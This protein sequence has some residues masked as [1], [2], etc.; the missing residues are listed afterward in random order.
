[1]WVL[2][3]TAAAQGD[4]D[5][6]RDPHGNVDPDV[7]PVEPGTYEGAIRYTSGSGGIGASDDPC[8]YRVLDYYEFQLWWGAFPGNP[9]GPPPQTPEDPDPD[10]NYE[11]LWVVVWCTAADGF[12]TWLDGFQ[13]GEPPPPDAL[14]ENARRRLVIPL[15]AAQFSPDPTTGASQVVGLETWLWVDPLDTVDQ[16]ITACVPA[17][18]PYA[19]VAITAEFR[20]TGFEM[21]DGS[22]EIYCDGPG[23]PYDTALSYEDQADLAHCG[24]VFT[25]ADPGGSTYPV[26]ATTFWQVDWS[27]RYDADLDG[28]LEAFCGGGDLGVVG[29]SQ[30]PV[31]LDVLDLQARAVEN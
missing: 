18:A 31:P 22:A 5:I 26:V 21:G 20:D 11:E 25:D 9:G 2:G 6:F 13:I 15:P 3:S 17:D 10:G 24:H 23:R 7:T 29:R 19:C 14:L 16:T 27:C 12:L 1:M 28:V 30:A 8:T 4:G